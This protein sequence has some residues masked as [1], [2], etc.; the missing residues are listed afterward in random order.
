MI[1]PDTNLLIYAYDST[2]AHHRAA[3]AWWERT[4]SDIEPVG[5]PWVVVLAF[6]RL[7]THP[8]LSSNPMTVDQA[9]QRVQEWLD[10]PHIRLLA[11][12]VNTLGRFFDLLAQAGTGGNF[13]TDALIAATAE[14]HGGTVCSN[15]ADFGRFPGVAWQNPLSLPQRAKYDSRSRR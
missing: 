3:R 14:E 8:S 9:R 4:L 11:P 12:T 13:C 2:A 7:M 1:V 15:D 10:H 6:V 5:I